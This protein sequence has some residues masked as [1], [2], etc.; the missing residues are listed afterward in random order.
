M[1]VGEQKKGLLIV[2][3]V[4]IIIIGITIVFI[5]A[6]NTTKADM[7]SEIP[8]KP[9][10]FI[11]VKHRVESGQLVDIC[12]LDEAYWK[13]PEFYPTW[14][15]GKL[16]FYDQHDYSRWIV[17]GYGAYPGTAGIVLR[18]FKEGE[19]FQL[20]TIVKSAYGTETWQG[21]KLKGTE[22]EY[23]EINI[24]SQEFEDYP[25]HFVLEPTFP[26]FKSEWAK[27][28]IF[29]VTAKKDVPIGEYQLGINIV[30][31]DGVFNK[32]MYKEIMNS[33]QTETDYIKKCIQQSKEN[34]EKLSK[35]CERMFTEREK[36]YVPGGGYKIGRDMYTLFVEVIE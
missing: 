19:S 26:M 12:G 10:D 7:F 2:F 27:M 8:E 20:C 6:T 4:M 9:E 35:G 31:P 28:V 29:N 30:K 3:S 25:D 18:N 32:N 23:L 5:I 22:D 34:P 21:I 13:H 36:I 1:Q 11:G 15:R 14:D 33:E 24:V 17:H 16:I